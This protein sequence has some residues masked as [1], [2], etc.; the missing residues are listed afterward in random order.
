VVFCRGG[1]FLMKSRQSSMLYALMHYNKGKGSF[2]TSS[3]VAQ[4]LGVVQ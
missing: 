4:E 1:G 2:S 3:V